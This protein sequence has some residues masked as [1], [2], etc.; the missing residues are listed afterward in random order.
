MFI[1]KV[2]WRVDFQFRGNVFL[3]DRK[4]LS[5]FATLLKLP[6]LPFMLSIIFSSCIAKILKSCDPEGMLAV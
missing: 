2:N 4:G 1:E 5:N 3:L 6:N